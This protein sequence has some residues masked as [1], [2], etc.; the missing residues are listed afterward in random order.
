VEEISA[1]KFDAIRKTVL[2][3]EGVK[4][5]LDGRAM[6]AGNACALARPAIYAS[7]LPA[8]YPSA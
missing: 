2:F 7:G 1:L 8:S 6:G 3:N 5:R 4:M